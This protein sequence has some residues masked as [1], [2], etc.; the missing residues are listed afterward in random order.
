MRKFVCLWLIAPL[1][2][3]KDKNQ[4]LPM[5][6]RRGVILGFASRLLFPLPPSFLPFSFLFLLAVC[7]LIRFFY[8][9][10]TFNFILKWEMLLYLF[11]YILKN[12]VENDL[13]REDSLRMEFSH[14][15]EGGVTC[16]ASWER[17]TMTF[18]WT[19]HMA[20]VSPLPHILPSPE[21]PALPHLAAAEWLVI[22]ILKGINNM[23]LGFRIIF[24]SEYKLLNNFALVPIPM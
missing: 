12:I 11:K 16:E 1:K 22:S 17:L 21:H 20:R 2:S 5:G 3:A 8:N 10:C 13:S 24:A 9:P 6:P 19:G 14:L 23:Y 15:R 7:S 4:R 18:W